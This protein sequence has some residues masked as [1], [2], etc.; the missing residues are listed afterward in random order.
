METAER[1]AQALQS[2]PNATTHLD[3]SNSNLHR[4][5]PARLAQVLQFIPSI[6][7]HLDLFGSGLDF[8]ED[9]DRQEFIR[10]LL[11][12]GISIQIE[13]PFATKLREAR[14]D[15]LTQYG[16][17]FDKEKSGLSPE[18]VNEI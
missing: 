12:S 4:F 2:I 5:G 8:L 17:F 6:V 15:K 14:Q 1:L 10:V 9:V 11:E 16:R 18:L 7:T 3:L 13:E